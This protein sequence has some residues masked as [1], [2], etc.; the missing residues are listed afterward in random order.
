MDQPK[1][2]NRKTENATTSSG[3]TPFQQEH[4]YQYRTPIPRPIRK[5]L[6]QRSQAQQYLQPK[7]HQGQL[8]LPNNTKQIIDNHNKHILTTSIQ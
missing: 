7:E 3:T 8:Q 1:K 2:S 4:Q 5:A 6:S